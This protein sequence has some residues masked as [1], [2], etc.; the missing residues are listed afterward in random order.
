MLRSGGMVTET[1][2]LARYTSKLQSAA[3]PEGC[4][5]RQPPL[6]VFRYDRDLA[7]T[8]RNS[9]RD[10]TLEQ[11]LHLL[12]HAAHSMA[13]PSAH[14]DPNARTFQMDARIGAGDRR[15][16]CGA[17]CLRTAEPRHPLIFAT[18][19]ASVGA[20]LP[21]SVSLRLTL[22]GVLNVVGPAPLRDLESNA[23]LLMP[24]LDP[25]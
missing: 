13:S 4:G 24:L 11:R 17:G 25:W 15:L 9:P 21:L 6:L 20:L 8:G 19:L 23:R 7:P 18:A 1:S 10:R 22:R 5:Q 16:D 14:G 12:R 3:S 2:F